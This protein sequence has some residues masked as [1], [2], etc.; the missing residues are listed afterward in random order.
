MGAGEIATLK[1][2]NLFN[3]GLHN[4]KTPKAWKNA[5]I[6]LIHKKGDRR[7]LKNYRPISLLSVIFKLHKNHHNSHLFH[8]HTHIL[9]RK[10]ETT[11]IPT[12]PRSLKTE[13]S[14]RK[15]K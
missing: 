2:A 6:T 7:D 14:K 10:N 11:K 12:K 1:L 15:T 4:G 13:N 5:T 8:T 9:I 3:K